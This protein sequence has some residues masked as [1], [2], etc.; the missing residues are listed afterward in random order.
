[1]KMK[2]YLLLGMALVAGMFMFSSCGD[3][4]EIVPDNG[5]DIE[6]VKVG[7]SVFNETE[8]QM[9]LSWTTSVATIKMSSKII[10]DFVDDVCSKFVTE[11]TY[12]SEALAKQAYEESMAAKDE[13]ENTVY[14]YKGKVMTVDETADYQGTPKDQMRQLLKSIQASIGK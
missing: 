2:K 10:V 6:D 5:G 13:S 8:N 7:N 14:S 1:M 12:P 3:D 4:D 9:T 11:T